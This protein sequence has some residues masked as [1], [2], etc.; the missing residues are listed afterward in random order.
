MSLNRYAKRADSTQT[1]IVEALRAAGAKVY[2]ISKP[3]DLLVR[4]LSRAYGHYLWTPMEVKTARGK[5]V[6]KARVDKR[7][8]EQIAFLEESGTPVVT[9]PEQA[10]RVIGAV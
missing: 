5:K 7:Q 6:P 9:T 1:A 4:Y 10:L 8:Q 3:C 2:V